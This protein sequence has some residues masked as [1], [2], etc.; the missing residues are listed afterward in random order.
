MPIC[1]E[2]KRPF[3]PDKLILTVFRREWMHF[4]CSGPC[5]DN[6]TYPKLTNRTC[7]RE[8]CKNKVPEGNRMLCLYCYH[9]EANLGERIA[10]F[11]ATMRVAWEQREEAIR[12]RIVEKVRVYS[13]QDMT[14]E[15]LRA[16]VPSIQEEAV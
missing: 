2:C 7:S 3:G 12:L 1:L 15:E 10:W 14:Q 9:N 6:Y 5:K 11:N 13:A 8:G 16:L 4:F